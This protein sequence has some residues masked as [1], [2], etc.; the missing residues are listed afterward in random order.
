MY[1]N[2]SAFSTFQLQIGHSYLVMG[3]GSKVKAQ[4]PPLLE[5]SSPVCVIMTKKLL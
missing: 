2:Y 1:Y 3:E 5:H 4:N